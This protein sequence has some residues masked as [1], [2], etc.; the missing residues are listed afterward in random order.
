MEILSRNF[1]GATE[2]NH[3]KPVRIFC[4]QAEIRT[5]HLPNTNLDNYR[6]ASL[7]GL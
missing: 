2:E 5:E 7:F 6:H 3:E 4:V 1:P